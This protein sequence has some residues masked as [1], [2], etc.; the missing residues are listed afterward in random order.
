L[1]AAVPKRRTTRLV[2]QRILVL[3]NLLRRAAGLRYR[4]LVGLQPGEWGVVAELGHH[5]PCTLNALSERIGV[6]KTQLSRT[7]ARL[8]ARGMVR[9]R[10]NPR[11]NREVWLSLSPQGTECYTTIMRAG[12][13]ANRSLLADL[14]AREQ[15]RLV[16]LIER[17]S[18]RARE[19]LRQ[20]GS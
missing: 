11:D 16:A 8:I 12:A 1:S 18:T 19:L 9:R 4:R 10:R 13:A 7:V 3:S 14:S 5:S 20:E 6:D 17:V 15:E 2:S